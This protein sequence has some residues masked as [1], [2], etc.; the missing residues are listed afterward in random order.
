M[1]LF[2]SEQRPDNVIPVSCW[3]LKDKPFLYYLG[4]KI[5]RW[6][7]FILLLYLYLDLYFNRLITG[8]LAWRTA[9]VRG[10]FRCEWAAA[11]AD[12]LKTA[13]CVACFLEMSE[14]SFSNLLL[15]C[16]EPVVEEVSHRTYDIVD[17][18]TPYDLV[19][20]KKG[21]LWVISQLFVRMLSLSIWYLFKGVQCLWLSLGFFSWSKCSISWRR[22]DRRCSGWII[23]I[24]HPCVGEVCVFRG[25]NEIRSQGFA[26]GY[27]LVDQDKK[28][29]IS[30]WFTVMQIQAGQRNL[31][32]QVYRIILLCGSQVDAYVPLYW[33][34]T[35]SIWKKLP[36]GDL[37]FCFYWNLLG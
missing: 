2:I 6:L 5:W 16:W 24:P 1:V 34:I 28:K 32:L 7:I 29:R 31:W 21:S 4:L 27:L 9:W 37:L 35:C 17:K 30:T 14:Q 33:I 3:K 19:K 13:G 22:D 8:Q 26:S 23:Y 11:F 20:L 10:S 15:S 18:G 25:V 12:W 36:I